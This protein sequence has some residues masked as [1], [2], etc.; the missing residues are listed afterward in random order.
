MANQKAFYK[1]EG[2]KLV[3][4]EEKR[5]GWPGVYYFHIL[6]PWIVWK[7]DCQRGPGKLVVVWFRINFQICPVYNCATLTVITHVIQAPDV[8]GWNV[9]RAHQLP[10]MLL[11][12][13]FFP[14]Q[15]IFPEIYLLI[16][17]M[18][19]WGLKNKRGEKEPLKTQVWGLI[20]ITFGR[21]NVD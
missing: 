12:L 8:Q 2:E 5:R 15:T 14:Y 21:S 16:F 4:R 17:K 13:S 18:S 1:E 7:D 6:K 3:E 19:P 11:S 10:G 9:P 20:C